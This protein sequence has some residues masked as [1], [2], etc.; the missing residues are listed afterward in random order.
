MSW[1]DEL[2]EEAR[3]A[4][5]EDIKEN[6]TLSRY[7][8]IEDMA[9]G[10]IEIRST[11]GNSIRIPTEDA[12]VD[13]VKEFTDK[14]VERVPNLMYK[15][16]FEDAEQ[17]TEFYRTLGRPEDISG[18]ENPEGTQLEEAVEEEIRAMALEAN[19][20]ASQYKK[21]VA[22][23]STRAEQVTES[24]TQAKAED[25]N[26]LKDK[27]GLTMD[28][29][30]GSAM[31]V[32]E[33]FFPGR[34]FDRLSSKE[35]EGLYN[36]S[37]AVTGKGAQAATHGEQTQSKLTPDEITEQIAAISRNPEL[38]DSRNPARQRELTDK[39]LALMKMAGGSDELVSF[40]N[41]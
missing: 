5:P 28:D 7:K 13:A 24:N 38:F 33:E 20:S 21:F 41:R 25:L 1:I 14:L 15:P 4:L 35:I 31:R 34:P 26:V 8:S 36:M 9:Q 19:L 23:M 2:S 32:N 16:K 12:G 10:H 17:T 30:V 6:P 11:L 40:H 18:Y 29:R 39:R 3:S 22:G 37:K 27:W